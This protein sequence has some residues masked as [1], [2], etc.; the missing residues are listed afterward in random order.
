MRKMKNRFSKSCIRTGFIFI[1]CWFIGTTLFAQE[2]IDTELWT[3][4]TFELQLNEKFRAEIEQ[5][6]RFNDT[7]S[8][9]KSTFTEPGIRYKL[10]KHISFKVK[11]RYTVR[12]DDDNR[13]RISFSGYYRWSKKKFPLSFQYRL[14]FQDTKE[15]NTGKKFTFLRNKFTIQY[16]L[17]KKADP[18]LAYE[19]FYK[20]NKKNEPR[21][22]R[23]TA[24]FDWKLI[25]SLELSTFYRYE[26]EMN[27]KKPEAQHIIGIMFTYETKIKG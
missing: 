14:K 27:V 18:F 3:G 16:N 1:I 22:W 8:S 11:Y 7:L 13:S 5:Q 26:E 4:A 20:F 21:A 10:N 24:G 15:Q 19:H 12:P 9:Y 17:S 6:V 25:K 23:F 2:I